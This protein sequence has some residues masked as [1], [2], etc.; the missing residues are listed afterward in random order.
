MKHPRWPT[1]ALALAALLALA[2]PRLAETRA[3]PGAPAPTT[4]PTIPRPDLAT[5]P[6]LAVVRVVDGDT[7]VVDRDGKE[8][9]VRLLGIDTPETKDP[10]KPVEFFAREASDFTTN[11]LKAE[12]VYVVQEQPG[13]K[14]KYGRTLAHVYRAPDG[15][16]VNL[17]LVRQGYAQVYSAQAFQDIDLFLTFQR[18][19][20]EAEKGLWNPAGK[21][22]ETEAPAAMPAPTAAGKPAAAAETPQKVTVYVTR[23]GAKY[24]KAGCS[25]L[26]SS[27]PM[28]LEEAKKRY[29]PCSK[30]SPPK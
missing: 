2:A 3:E 15:L 14:D 18:R 19:A 4:L 13:A 11:L 10:R 8:E 23:S 7:I 17:E 9:T 16:W 28:D 26:K 30:C 27:I 1:I 5:A 24:H 22:A 20:R 25:Y 21:A 6:A 29:G 12:Q